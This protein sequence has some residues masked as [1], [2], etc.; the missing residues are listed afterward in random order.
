MR[1]DFHYI[2]S[3]YPGMVRGHGCIDFDDSTEDKEYV[4]DV[5]R[6]LQSEAKR[7]IAASPARSSRMETAFLSTPAPPVWN[8]QN[9][10]ST[11]K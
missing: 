3:R 6:T 5:K 9:V 2:A 1:R 10:W 11:P 7:E 8:W 4:F